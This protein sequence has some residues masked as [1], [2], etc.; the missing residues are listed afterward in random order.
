MKTRVV[1]VML[2]ASVLMG[3]ALTTAPGAGAPDPGVPTEVRSALDRFSKE[4]FRANMRFLADDL[5]EGR[6]T[7]TRGQALAAH[8]VAAQLQ[9]A[10]LEPGGAGGSWFQEV[11]LR[12]VT[13]DAAASE[14]SVTRDGKSAGLK[15]GDD[16]V[17]RGNELEPDASIEAPVVFVGYGVVNP[18]RKY[19]D[20]AGADVKGKIVAFLGGGPPAFP[21]NERA[22]FAAPQQKFREAAAHGA[23]GIIRLW[24]PESETLLPWVRSA[25]QA[26]VPAFRW[27][28]TNGVPHDTHKEIRVY[29][30]LSLGAAKGMFAGA[31]STYE[32]TLEKAKAGTLRAFT[33]PVTVRMHALSRHRAVTSPNV[34]GVLRGSDPALAREYVVYSA[35]TDHLGIGAAVNGDTIYNGAVDDA[36]GTS[37]LIELARA[38]GRLEKKPARSLLFLATTGE[39]A[40]LLGADYFVHAPTVPID[41]IVAD[42]NMDTASVFYAFK[43]VV[44]DEHSTLGETIARDAA[45][46][47]LQVSP[48]PMPEQVGFVR[49][50]HYPFVR[51]GIPAVTI[52][53]GLQ[54]RDPKVDGRKV[55]TAWIATRYHA[56]ADDMDQPLDLD[57]AIEYLQLNFLVGYEVA[58]DHTRPTWKHGDFFGDLFGARRQ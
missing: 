34:V 41:S 37:A 9:A 1:V 30:T 51:Q 35:H 39:E 32:D 26:R 29:A 56:P 8:Y 38:F 42:V 20:Y 27:L 44:G 43:D 45:R 2:F 58:Q 4:A 25:S 55:V 33:F 22:H 11:P 14:I 18:A 53:E 24:T 15:W 57:A 10:G 48:D 5:L 28:E 17:M 13:I 40:G 21:A 31:P 6:G 12:E 49:A 47:G 23:A 7:A 54:A 50:D 36:S 52:G 3:A 19:D 46:L 16:F